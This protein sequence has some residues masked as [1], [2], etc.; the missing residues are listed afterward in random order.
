MGVS[1]NFIPTDT[2]KVTFITYTTEIFN[3]T[4]TISNF[5]QLNGT[6]S[7]TLTIGGKIALFVTLMYN[8][9]DGTWDITA[10]NLT[11]TTV[12]TT[13]V[14]LT[15][16]QYNG[17]TLNKNQGLNFSVTMAGACTLNNPIGYTAG[18]RISLL[19]RQD[20]V[21][22]H[23]LYYGSMYSFPGAQTVLLSTDGSVMDRLL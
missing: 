3:I 13:E 16:D 11:S 17:I 21:G 10:N 1:L 20:S 7:T 23:Q 5:R 2:F 22:A 9:V 19:I 15:P 12:P 4:S 18:D 8:V 14:V 6:M